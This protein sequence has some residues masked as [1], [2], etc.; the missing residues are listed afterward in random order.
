MRDPPLSADATQPPTT[1]NR[2]AG[3]RTPSLFV[4]GRNCWRVEHARRFAVLID[5]DAYFRAVRRAIAEARH[6]IFIVGWDIDSRLRL[7]PEGAHDGFPQPLG[8]FL[9]AVVASRRELRAYAL[10]WDFAML[11]ALE[12]EWLPV[13]KL[14][15]TTHR[16]LAFRLDGGHP[17]GASHHQKIV[18]IDDAVAFVGGLDLTHTRWDTPEHRTRHPLRVNGLGFA[19]GPMHDVQ[20]VVDG[21]AAR[22]LGD[23]ARE[24]W[25][26]AT[27]CGLRTSGAPL[28]HDPWPASCVPDIENVD[29]AI[30]RTDPAYDGRPQV[31]EIRA[32]H[33][34]AIASARRW[35]FAENQYFSS[36]AIAKAMS[37]RLT[38][39]NPPEIVFVGPRE[40]SG[41][42][43][44]TTM[45]V[46]RARVERDIKAADRIGHFRA[47]CPTLADPE[48]I[49]V[50]S[51]V[52][53][54]DDAL[55]TIGSAN[56]SNRS[57]GF[58]TECNVA[59]ESRGNARIAAAIAG[60]R[61]RLLGEHLGVAPARVAQESA[62]RASLIG[63]IEAL[64]GEGRTLKPYHRELSPEADAMVPDR[65]VIDPERPIDPD[66]LVDDL[67]PADSRGPVRT[68]VIALVLVIVALGMIA[69][70]WRFTPLADYLRLSAIADLGE[71]LRN[72]WWSPFAVLAA[73]V[74]GAALVV[75]IMLTVAAT[76]MLFGPWLG[77][78]YACTGVIISGVTSYL[79][80]RHLGRDTVRRIG[81]RRLNELSR[82]LAKRGLLAVFVIRHLPIA[83]YSIVNMVCGASHIRLRDFVFGTMLGMYPATI[84]T[85]VFVDRAIAAIRA[86][87][88]A[89]VAMLVGAV[90]V[91]VAL[92]IFFRRRVLVATASP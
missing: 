58:D 43:E 65:S 16:R 36:S 64:R 40:E 32:L 88:A 59:I 18:V 55:A 27:G 81:G 49:N 52:M 89:T 61:N 82:R 4:P 80:G 15:T 54:V 39:Q 25:R 86:P 70:A 84:I 31:E 14:H 9:N 1:D 41:W 6:S 3:E 20:V 91:A 30:A 50:H 87:S 68:R 11:Y 77:T 66:R 24:R 29:V 42:L 53:V 12:R 5:A 48:C 37:S 92:V 2:R 44:A 22:A 85:V 8:E 17:V 74:A 56:L 62:R 83:P 26:R 76:G 79:I 75:P 78:L 21:D 10:S 7:V 33:L 72:A 45:G 51:K 38:E 34:D 73:Y 60:I 90:A 23:L 63:A 35:I 13:F 47:Y 46:L 67:V 69:A 28:A 19:Y 57:M 71:E